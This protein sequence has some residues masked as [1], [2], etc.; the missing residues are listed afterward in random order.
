MRRS[1]FPTS[2]S[3]LAAFAVAFTLACA[4]E[5]EPRRE[6]REQRQP[7]APR[8]QP[9][10]AFSHDN[11]REERWPFGLNA[12]TTKFVAEPA[13][14]QHFV[15]SYWVVRS[16]AGYAA[17]LGE[18]RAEFDVRAE[19][20]ASAFEPVRGVDYELV[21]GEDSS[22][23]TARA[24]DESRIEVRSP[25]V[26]GARQRGFIVRARFLGD[27]TPH[28]PPKSLLVELLAVRNADGR[29]L[30]LGEPRLARWLIVE[31]ATTSPPSAP[32]TTRA[33]SREGSAVRDR[34]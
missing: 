25:A 30:P 28:E 7:A 15:A 11:S 4:S 22:G 26:G 29:E 5:R 6:A 31:P 10:F 32:T 14:A 13:D 12:V 27:A 17:P 3:S 19:F 18:L 21:L 33:A 8:A 23:A 1:P 2:R 16:E 20:P 24:L 9:G 34:N